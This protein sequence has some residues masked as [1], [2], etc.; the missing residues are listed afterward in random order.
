MKRLDSCAITAFKLVPSNFPSPS[1]DT[2]EAGQISFCPP[3]VM[4][5]VLFDHGSLCPGLKASVAA[6][7]QPRSTHP[8]EALGAASLGGFSSSCRVGSALQVVTGRGETRNAVRAWERRGA[9]LQGSGRRGP[10]W[11]GMVARGALGV[12]LLLHL[13]SGERP[14]PHAYGQAWETQGQ[15]QGGG[16]LEQVLRGAHL[17]AAAPPPSSGSVLLSR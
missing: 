12:L 3:S 17:T 15:G 2:G 8:D 6:E 16:R 1:C 4:G 9:Q 7:P 5:A 11:P 13:A 10:G 14:A